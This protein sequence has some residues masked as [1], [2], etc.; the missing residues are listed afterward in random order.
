MSCS[1][2]ASSDLYRMNMSAS[3]TGSVA[4]LCSD[5]FTACSFSRF[6]V[7]AFHA[8]LAGLPWVFRPKRAAL[9]APS[10]IRKGRTI[11]RTATRGSHS[12]ED[13]AALFRSSCTE[14]AH[15]CLYPAFR[16]APRSFRKEKMPRL[17]FRRSIG[18]LSACAK[19]H[20]SHTCRTSCAAGNGAPTDPMNLSTSIFA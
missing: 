16:Q 17:L 8:P 19:K 18:V 2:P 1:H 4:A 11:F 7:H 20:E 14:A 9:H 15:P 3:R 12:A 6:N 5:S 13:R 10:R